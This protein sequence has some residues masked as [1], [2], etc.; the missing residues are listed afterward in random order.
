MYRRVSQREHNYI[1]KHYRENQTF[2][3]KHLSFHVALMNLVSTLKPCEISNN[4]KNAQAER[5]SVWIISPYFFFQI[6]V[7]TKRNVHY[8]LGLGDNLQVCTTT[9]MASWFLQFRS[10][11]NFSDANA[12]L[13][14]RNKV[15][16]N[17][18]LNSRQQMLFVTF[19]MFSSS[20]EGLSKNGTSRSRF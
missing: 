9:R 18:S 20:S 5:V 19:S 7:L 16:A 1:V 2:L 13:R 14:V 6:T 12:E 4:L 15:S 3:F 10:K 8:E 11:K 17:E